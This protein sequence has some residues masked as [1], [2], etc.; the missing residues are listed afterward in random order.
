MT[1]NTS[2]PDKKKKATKKKEAPKA[3]TSASKTTNPLTKTDEGKLALKI[4]SEIEDMIGKDEACKKEFDTFVGL[5]T[6]NSMMIIH[7]NLSQGFK[8]LR[9]QG[10]TDSAFINQQLFQALEY[11][12]KQVIDG[13]QK[14]NWMRENS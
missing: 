11:M 10:I 8:R 6:Q 4:M 9:S 2:T 3:K 14:R 1:Q 5:S 13:M 7:D 12:N